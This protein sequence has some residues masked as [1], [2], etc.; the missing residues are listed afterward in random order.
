MALP[1]T[2]TRMPQFLI[3]RWFGWIDT[4]H[5]LWVP[6]FLGSAFNIFLL[7]QFFIQVPKELEDA[8]KI[9]GCSYFKTYWNVVLPQVKPALAAIAVLTFIG[10]WNDFQGPLIY[11]NSTEK[12]PISY[13]LQLFQGDRSTE[14]GLLM[15]FATMTFIPVVVLFFLTQKYIVENTALSGLGGR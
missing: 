2:I 5:P 12:M 8:A 10:V 7:R 4:L 3:F 14:F 9:D 15:A 11:I 13:T 6:A 1:A